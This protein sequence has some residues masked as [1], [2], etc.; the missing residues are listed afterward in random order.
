[1]QRKVSP[2]GV[3]GED[4][5][6]NDQEPNSRQYVADFSRHMNRCVKNA[7]DTVVAALRNEGKTKDIVFLDGGCGA[8]RAVCYLDKVHSVAALG[9]DQ[10]V[11]VRYAVKALEQGMMLFPGSIEHLPI[12]DEVV[13]MYI[14]L[15]VF[16]HVEKGCDVPLTEARRILKHDGYLVI[17][18]PFINHFRSLFA[19]V[20]MVTNM[21][22][23]LLGRTLFF[24]E[25]RYTRRD[26]TEAIERNGFKVIT[27]EPA[28][29]AGMGLYLDFPILRGNHG[30]FSLNHAGKIAARIFNALSPYFTTWGLLC[31]CRKKNTGK[32]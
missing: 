14:S 13:D 2:A 20:T 25:Y 7:V 5:G 10:N 19:P 16:E 6:L 12:R 23:Y 32:M 27:I 8:G 26:L 1:M 21:L 11:G 22:R 30:A 31:V 3:G 18:V 24:M 28:D 29:V 4:W 15:G 17:T 9:I